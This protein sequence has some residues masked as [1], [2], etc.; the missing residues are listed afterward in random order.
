MKFTARQLLLSLVEDDKDLHASFKV[1]KYDRITG[2][3][4]ENRCVLN[5]LIKRCLY[6]GRIDILKPCTGGLCEIPEDYHYSSARFYLDGTNEFGI[7]KHF[8]G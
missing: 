5:C 8:S 7:L 3:G 2:H 1:N 4:K 6:K